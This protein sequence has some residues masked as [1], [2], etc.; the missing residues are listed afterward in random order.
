M[1]SQR[2]SQTRRQLRRSRS[3]SYRWPPAGVFCLSVAQA[4]LPV[5]NGATRLDPKSLAHITTSFFS[6]AQAPPAGGHEND[7][8]APLLRRNPSDLGSSI[9]SHETNAR[10]QARACPTQKQH[11]HAFHKFWHR[12]TD[13]GPLAFRTQRNHVSHLRRFTSANHK[14]QGFHPGLTYAA[15]T[16]LTPCT[17]PDL[18]PLEALRREPSAFAKHWRR[19]WATHRMP[20]PPNQRRRRETH[21]AQGGSPGYTISLNCLSAVGA[22]HHRHLQ[23]HTESL[24]SRFESPHHLGLFS[25]TQIIT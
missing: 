13:V 16:A 8:C 9:T 2:R 24:K 20:V 19:R 17:S 18:C 6:V 1:R 10:G 7:A 21:L 25:S 4:I 3:S 23:H 5:P 22:T 14:S 11:T 12:I 15:P